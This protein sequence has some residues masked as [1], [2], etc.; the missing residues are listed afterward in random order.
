MSNMSYCRFQNTVQDFQDC[1][2]NIYEDDLSKDERRARIRL[3]KLAYEMVQDFLD[4]EGQLDMEM[5]ND[6]QPVKAN[7]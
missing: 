3:I 1:L 7:A 4:N 6:L 2:D 5:V